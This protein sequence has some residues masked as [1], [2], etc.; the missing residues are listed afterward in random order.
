[1]L[2]PSSRGAV[3]EAGC[4]VGVVMVA[5]YGLVLV[6][7][8]V[9]RRLFFC[10]MISSAHTYPPATFFVL[11]HYP[12]S[13]ISFSL[14]RRHCLHVSSDGSG[15]CWRYPS[16][17]NEKKQD[18][19]THRPLHSIWEY[20]R[21]AWGKMTVRLAAIGGITIGREKGR[22]L[23]SLGRNF[24]ILPSSVTTT[25]AIQG[26]TLVPQTR[27]PSPRPPSQ[28]VVGLHLVN[29]NPSPI[30]HPVPRNS[31]AG[32][33][34]ING[35]EVAFEFARTPDSPSA[36][37]LSRCQS[38]PRSEPSTGEVEAKDEWQPI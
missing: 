21:T 30:L 13:C 38:P 6:C 1:M 5:C 10:F 37:A 22:D 4:R 32:S 17:R 29:Y 33:Q 27:F 28:P 7:C 26:V 14:G 8:F 19:P 35:G 24:W 23:K 12:C 34:G 25:S 2:P 9:L 11:L 15:S 20:L 3:D 16:S 36:K 31:G 18:F